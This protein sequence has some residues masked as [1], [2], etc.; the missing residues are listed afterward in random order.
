MTS[1]V[2]LKPSALRCLQR[3][4]EAHGAWISGNALADVAGWRFGGRVMELRQAGYNV[5]RRPSTTR[6]A[7]H[8]YRLPA[9]DEQLRIAL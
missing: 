1:T 7:V 2:H 4:Q 5:E 6:S 9:V 3:L 8:E